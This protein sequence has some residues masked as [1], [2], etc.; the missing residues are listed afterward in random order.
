MRGAPGTSA[1]A[2]PEFLFGWD[3]KTVGDLFDNVR[4]EMPPG[5]AGTLTDQQY[6][7][8]LAA[9]FKQNDFPAG[10]VELLPE[11]KALGTFLITRDKR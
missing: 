11:R 10:D 7:D 4:T 9:I 2:G 1:L 5:Q 8:V 6:A 3:G